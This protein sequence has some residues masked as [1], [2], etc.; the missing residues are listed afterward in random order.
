MFLNRKPKK[1]QSSTEFMVIVS[2]LLLFFCVFLF[3][4]ES[5]SSDKM[6][7]KQEEVFRES[8]LS[9]KNEID[10]AFKASDGYKREFFILDKLNNKNYSV[11]IIENK[12]YLNSSEANYAIAFSIPDVVGNLIKGVNKIEKKTGVIYLNQ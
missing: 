4:V 7:E 8:A 2:F 6:R 9:I 12:V 5:K 1:S 11:E 10:L 3:T